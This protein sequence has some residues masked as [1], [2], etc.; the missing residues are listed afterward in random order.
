MKKEVQT[1]RYDA[2]DVKD[3]LKEGSLTLKISKTLLDVFE[4][5]L[6]H[7][8]T[9]RKIERTTPSQPKKAEN[10]T[11]EVMHAISITLWLLTRSLQRAPRPTRPPEPRLLELFLSLR[12]LP[13]KVTVGPSSYLLVDSL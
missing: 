1:N 7:K 4:I 9:K 12:A 8:C 5:P 13:R 11:I 2:N 3:K 10:T 6:F